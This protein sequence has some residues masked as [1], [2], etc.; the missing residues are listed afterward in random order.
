MNCHQTLLAKLTPKFGPHPENIAVESLGHILS[1]SPAAVRTLEDVLR[2]GGTEVGE[3]AK[4]KTQASGEGG[5]RPDLAGFDQHC[6]DRVLIE[7]KFWAGLTDKQPVAYLKRLSQN[8]ASALLFV[9][10]AK[11]LSSAWKGEVCWRAMPI[12][13]NMRRRGTGK[14]LNFPKQAKHGLGS[15]STGGR[16]IIPLSGFAYLIARR[17]SE[18][19]AYRTRTN[20]LRTT[21][22]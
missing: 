21:V 15:G 20:S 4:V 8:Q 14:N 18:S 13:P 16:S 9:A 10:P 11:R 22:P 2:T 3:I 1:T 5:T 19:P 7:A 6:K 17:T 12:P